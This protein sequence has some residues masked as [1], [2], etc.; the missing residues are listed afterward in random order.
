MDSRG[1]LLDSPICQTR[2]EKETSVQ[3]ASRVSESSDRVLS[4]QKRRNGMLPL[5]GHDLR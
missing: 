5:A 4:S 1:D 2:E 3:G